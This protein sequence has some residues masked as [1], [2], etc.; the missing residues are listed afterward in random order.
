MSIRRKTA[1]VPAAATAVRGLSAGLAALAIS[2]CT[3]VAVVGGA[4]VA[5]GSVAV[6]AA[7]TVVEAAV[8]VT[9]AGV[10]AVAG[11]KEEKQGE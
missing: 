11:S 1:A 2:G 10:K 7:A 5:V 9:V 8:D 4:A 6:G 3:T